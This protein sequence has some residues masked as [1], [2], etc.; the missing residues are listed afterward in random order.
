MGNILEVWFDSP[1]DARG[2]GDLRGGNGDFGE[3]QNFGRDF[4]R[5]HTGTSFPPLWVF[6]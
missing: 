2:E 4:G 5:F 1:T 6:C 3:F